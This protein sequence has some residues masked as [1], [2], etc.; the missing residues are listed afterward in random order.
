MT[1]KRLVVVYS[2]KGEAI[3]S[4]RNYKKYIKSLIKKMELFEVAV[5]I[6]PEGSFYGD[7]YEGFV[8]SL[9]NGSDSQTLFT[10][11]SLGKNHTFS[12]SFKQGETQEEESLTP[13]EFLDV[14]TNFDPYI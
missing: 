9:K 11:S 12:S 6:I 3:F 13:K 5:K 2:D 14:A 10:V 7:Q 1:K 4:V 8:L